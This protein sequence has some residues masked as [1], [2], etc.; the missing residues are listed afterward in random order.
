MSW[1]QNMF[2]IRVK[3]NNGITQVM[4][5]KIVTTLEWGP[6]DHNNLHATQ[7]IVGKRTQC[8]SR[9][10]PKLRITDWTSRRAINDFSGLAFSPIV[11]EDSFFADRRMANTEIGTPSRLEADELVHSSKSFQAD[12]VFRDEKESH[13]PCRKAA[14]TL[15]QDG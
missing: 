9:M 14:N 3:K 7:L 10:Q 1:N 8:S 2:K 5:S 12:E 6:S 4:L 13:I 15:L 11:P